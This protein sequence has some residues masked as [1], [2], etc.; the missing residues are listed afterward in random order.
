MA[1]KS[2]AKKAGPKSSA[3]KKSA[4]KKPA[5][6]KPTGKKPVEKKPVGKKPVAKT[7]G[8]KTSKP[9]QAAAAKKLGPLKNQNSAKASAA[10]KATATKATAPKMIKGSELKR[11]NPLDDRI[12]IESVVAP[13]KTAGGLFIPDMA[14]EKP[15]LGRVVAVGRGH[16]DAKGRTRPCD[17]K[18]GD[19]VLFTAWSGAEI[20]VDGH[21]Y[22]IMR[23]TDL[24][25]VT[26]V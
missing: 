21:K 17:V 1:K 23:E 5:G 14:Q 10:T 13:E 6:K 25:G 26:T 15:T 18:V 4:Q 7:T 20:E 11:F 22:V 12:V 9:A 2:M 3:V 19:Q 24:L 8:S 16:R